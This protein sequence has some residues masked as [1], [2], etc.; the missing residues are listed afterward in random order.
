MFSKAFRVKSNT[1][2]KGS[3]RRKLRADVTTAF[4]TLSS[5]Q[6]SELVPNKEE[7][8][9]IKLYAHK[10]DAVT[11]YAN[12][13]N[14][15]L[16]ELEKTLY[17][18][19]YT[20]WSYPDLLPAFS[21]WPPVLQKLAGGA[22]LMLPGVMV[23]SRGLPQVQQGTLCAITLVGNRAPVAV[24]VAT[25][26]TGEML[27]AGMKG[28]GFA[29]LH[30]YTDHLWG[31]GDKL[32]P[33]TIAPLGAEPAE[34]ESTDEDDEEEGGREPMSDL[35]IAPSLQMDLGSLSLQ[36]GNSCTRL[37]EE[38]E[39][40]G[41][42]GAEEM[43]EDITEVQLETEDGRTPQE[44]MDELLH[45][46]FFHA[47]KCKVKKSEL[48]L[49]TSTF[50]RNHMFACCPE[51]QQL[52]I[53]K[54]SYKKLSKF[55]QHMQ[56]QKI[57]QVKELNKGVESIVDI[58]WKH[59]DIK[60]FVV[61]EALSEVSSAPENK[62]GDG[63]QLYHAPE[64]I[65]LYGVSSKM[66]P[67][68]QESGHKKGSILSSSDVRNIIIS[69]VKT[70]E[71]VDEA[72]KNFVKIN[73]ILCDCLLDKSEQDEILKLKWDDLLSRCLEKL[74]PHHQ[75]TF[76]GREPVVKKGNL[77]PIDITIAQRSSNKKVT[78]IKNLELYGLDPQLVANTLQQRVQAS[79]SINT[80]PGAKDRVQVQIQGNQINHLAKLL[81]EEYQLPRKYIQG[82][83]KAPKLS[84]K[85]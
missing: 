84:R 33:P 52:D 62:Y 45:Q 77:D 1:A 79:A 34:L 30:V 42:P 82:L 11:V 13:R 19:V 9:I 10:G 2:I 76:F 40:P 49:L 5:E 78:I 71:L 54:S 37:T 46:C 6:L 48:P 39:E 24:G 50:L 32:N 29:I 44:R 60:S 47:L 16:F 59:S 36:E 55:L 41:E 17:P 35:A 58:N 61:P 80:L 15:I 72:N 85:K 83:E 20:L 22:D 63:E 81:L 26:S 21:T 53:K 8:N 28:K 64:I 25:M 70:N 3:D 7:L 69:Y 73:P 65:P 23:S 57:V 4:P 43:A 74:Q 51:G 12:N 18:T 31:L 56:Q 66:A 67:L 14:P 68:F 27:A 38:E 75:M